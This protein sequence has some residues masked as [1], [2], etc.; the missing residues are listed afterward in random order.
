VAE[1]LGAHWGWVIRRENVLN[2]QVKTA[3][4]DAFLL[5]KTMLV[6]RNR[7]QGA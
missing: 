6:A 7:D 1:E 2:F 3:G 4:F 5:Q